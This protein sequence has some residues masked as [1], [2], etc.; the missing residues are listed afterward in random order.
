MKYGYLVGLQILPSINSGMC[1]LIGMNKDRI[2]GLSNIYKACLFLH[3]VVNP[4]SE[5]QYSNHGF[6]GSL[7]ETRSSVNAHVNVGPVKNIKTTS[8]TTLHPFLPIIKIPK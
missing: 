5:E 6:W 1:N 7:R 8:I 2:L 3:L 4:I